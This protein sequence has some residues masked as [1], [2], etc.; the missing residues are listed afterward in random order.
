MKETE[1]LLYKDSLEKLEKELHDV[2]E[3][4]DL[5]EKEISSGKEFLKQKETE[6]SEAEQKL[7][8]TEDLNLELCRTVEGLKRE[9]KEVEVTRKN[10]EKQILELSED[11]TR[12]NREIECLH[13]VNGN[14]ESELGM[15][16]KEI[17]EHR[18]REENLSSELQER[19]NEFELWEAEAATFYFD[20]QISAVR[21]VLFENKVHELAG[22]CETLEDESVSKNEE[23]EQMKERVGFM[24]SE[25]GGLKAQLFEYAPLVV[26]L[27]D[28]IASLEQ[29][30]LSWTKLNATD[31]QEPKVVESALHLHGKS[32]QELMEDSNSGIPNGISDLQELQ[33]RIK[34]VEKGQEKDE[35]KEERQLGDELNDNINLQKAKPKIPEVKN[36]EETVVQMIRCL[37]Y[38]KLLR[39]D[40]SIDHIV[41]ESRKQAYDAPAED[42]I[43][44]H[45][46]EAVE[47]E[48]EDP[49]SELQ[50]EKELGVDKL[51]VSR[52]V[53]ELNQVGNKRKILETLASDTQKLTSL[54]TTV[55]D[56]RRKLETNGRSK[57]AKDVDIETMKEQLLEV[58]ESVV[59]LVD[60]NGQLTKDV[61]ESPSC[62]NGRASPELEEAGNVQ[63]KRVSE[64]ART[65][66]EKIERLQ[67]EVQKIQY[68]LLKL[69][70]E[71]KGKGGDKFSRRTSTVLRDFINR[72]RGSSESGRKASFCGC[73][74]PSSS[75]NPGDV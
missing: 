8:A 54:Q 7:K 23:I 62:S 68:V 36:G 55:Q 43:V 40:R 16:H 17:E 11:N 24:E 14:L 72:G 65:G 53:T 71:K 42:D 48:S 41:N 3:I 29:N 70:D 64:Q 57:K 34:A 60:M 4:D 56:L 69:E 30:T 32:C 13:E 67:L 49:S 20:L 26:S 19:S 10:L 33:A 6:L 63:R 37:S 12:Q 1:N 25:I 39:T 15:L 18:I 9:C 74:R 21:E 66:S 73:F 45:Q 51:E 44:Y 59:E 22:V 52:S 46:F 31:N 28:N 58:E 47:R 75:G 2:R 50:V 38:G 27:R 35:Q 61:E 5:L